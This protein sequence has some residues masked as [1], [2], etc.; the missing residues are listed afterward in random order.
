[1]NMWGFP[2]TVSMASLVHG[3]HDD[4]AERHYKR[5]QLVIELTGGGGSGRDWEETG[6]LN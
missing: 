4:P 6:Q 5:A 2:V 3:A 1:M